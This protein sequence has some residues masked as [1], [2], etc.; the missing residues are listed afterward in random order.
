MGLTALDI[1]VLIVVG[2]AA[3]TGLMRSFVTEVL[4]LMAW[5]FVVFA[6]K[7]YFF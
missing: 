1:L 2:G 6:I 4:S 3:V 5:I 7:R